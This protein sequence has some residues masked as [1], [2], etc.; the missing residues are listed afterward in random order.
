MD[1]FSNQFGEALKVNNSRILS[2]LLISFSL[3]YNSCTLVGL[4]IGAIV[5]SSKSD[6]SKPDIKIVKPDDYENIKHSQIITVHLYDYSSKVGRF[7]GI[8]VV[9]ATEGDLRDYTKKY[10]ILKTGH[11]RN[12]PKTE[13]ISLDE[14]ISV[15]IAYKQKGK[16]N[17][18]KNGKYY[19]LGIGSLLDSILITIWLVGRQ[20]VSD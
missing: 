20:N 4:G 7:D 8:D 17:G 12:T 3:I 10:L 16:K 14:I 18:K 15:K 5:D 1:L 19:G 13:R 11:L 9:S 2:V 6:N